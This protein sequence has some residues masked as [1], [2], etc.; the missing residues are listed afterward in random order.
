LLVWPETYLIT[1][2]YMRRREF[3][4]LL[5]GATVIKPLTAW[6]QQPSL[7]LIGVLDAISKASTERNYEIFRSELRKLG[8]VD[9]RNMVC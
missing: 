8:Y 2:E 1:E 6:A 5:T 3:L 9:G 4:T 7:P